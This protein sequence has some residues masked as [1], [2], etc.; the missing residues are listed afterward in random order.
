MSFLLRFR[1]SNFMGAAS[2]RFVRAIL[3]SMHLYHRRPQVHRHSFVLVVTPQALHLR[4]EN[5]LTSHFLHRSALVSKLHCGQVTLFRLTCCSGSSLTLCMLLTF[6]RNLS[7]FSRKLC[8][9]SKDAA[10]FSIALS[11]FFWL[12]T[13]CIFLYRL[14]AVSPF[15]SA[16]LTTDVF[17]S[18]FPPSSLCSPLSPLPCPS[19]PPNLPLS[20]SPPFA[21]LP[22]SASPPFAALPLSA[23]PPPLL[24]VFSYF[25]SSASCSWVVIISCLRPLSLL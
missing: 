19:L 9:L 14:F 11:L 5:E 4:F 3:W 6:F 12:S 10:F 23:S 20:A 18:R 17:A 8:Q 21:A 15:S 7:S 1:S 24:L 13:S 16:S 25:S 2:L 22:L